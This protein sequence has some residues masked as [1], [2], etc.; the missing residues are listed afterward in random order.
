MLADVVRNLGQLTW[1]L[2]QMLAAYEQANLKRARAEAAYKTAHAEVILRAE[3]PMEERKARATAA[4]SD[5]LLDAELAVAEFDNLRAAMRVLGQRIDAG[6]TIAST[7]RAE[8]IAAG[9]GQ[10]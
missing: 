2:Q 8:G 9:T 5:L 6:R 1:E 3:G 10:T 4:T 7:M